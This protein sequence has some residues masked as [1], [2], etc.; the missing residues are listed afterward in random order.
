MVSSISEIK[1]YSTLGELKHKIFYQEKTVI[2]FAVGLVDKILAVALS[3]GYVNIY[4]WDSEMKLKYSLYG[5][6]FGN[7]VNKL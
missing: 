6:S 7:F 4:R 1:I 2:R 3:D 5:E